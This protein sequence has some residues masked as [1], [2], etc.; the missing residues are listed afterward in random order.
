MVKRH[1]GDRKPTLKSAQRPKEGVLPRVDVKKL[2]VVVKADSVGSCEA[3]VKA[4][5]E[6]E[7]PPVAVRVIHQGVGPISK[8]DVLMAATGSKL[9]LGFEVDQAPK[10]ESFARQ[11][12]VTILRFDVIYALV[13]EVE[14]RARSM[15][16]AP[17]A[18]QE[19]IFGKGRIIALFKSSRKGVII[20]CEIT[21][22][23]F[24]QGRKFRVISAMGPVY[25]GV[26]QSMQ[27]DRRPVREAHAG[28]QVGIKIPDWN[29]ARI[30]DLVEIYR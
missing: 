26:V 27:I 19:E 1:R 21:E 11:N 15:V 16:P 2:E 13:G 10:V 17:T 8:S 12:G 5:E 18:T 30:G 23:T 24:A 14:R 28:D 3:V 25:A 4:L 9:I 22:G 20:G 7:A 29:E 6:I